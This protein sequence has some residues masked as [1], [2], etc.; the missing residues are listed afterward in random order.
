MAR[1]LLRGPVAAALLDGERI[2]ATSEVFA[3][4]LGLSPRDCQGRRL[5][6]L[7][8]PEG[9][10]LELPSRGDA[11]SYR[12][13]LGGVA[14]RVDLSS[15]AGSRFGIAG[16]A[17]T[18]E[19]S[20][21]A[22]SRA[23]L[24][25]S[26]ELSAA[27]SEEELEGAVARALDLL[28][29]GR[30][31][32]IR[33]LDPAT[34]ALTSMRARGRLA[35]AMRHRLALRRS[36]VEKTGLSERKLLAA[37]AQVV[38]RDEPVFAGC[39]RATAVP[40]AVGGSLH[41]LVNLEYERGAPGTP[42]SDEPLLLQVANQAALAARNLR[43]REELKH[44]KSYLEDL[45]ENAP[46]L[47]AVVNRERELTVFN[48]AL[49]RLTGCPREEALGE[50]FLDLVPDG[51]RTRVDAL[52]EKGLAGRP[53]SGFETRLRL[54]SGGEAR[55]AINTSAVTGASGEVEGVMAIGHDTT[56]LRA[57]QERAEHGQRL[58][59]L[60][61][62]AAGV[63]HE[64]NNPLTAVAAYSENLLGKM[65]A[66]G[67]DPG[68][69]DKLRRIREAAG[70]LQRLSRD[71]MAYARPP[72]EQ[73][74][75]VDLADVI[76]RAATMCEPALKGVGARLE[77]QLE[78]VPVVFGQRDSLVQVFVNLISNAVQAL[79]EG[80][81][82]IRLELAREGNHVAARVRDDGVGMAPDVKKRIFEPFFTT[83]RDGTG[84]G[85]G[86][87]IVQGILARHAGAMSVESAPGLGTTFTVLFPVDL[88]P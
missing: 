64:L 22:Q 76:E 36:S 55:I 12:T 81:G 34:L 44:F 37:G 41:G 31:F 26:R 13:H 85:L 49:V 70:R 3:R 20:D 83:R 38:E 43:T 28:F 74:E 86:L 4:A 24:S 82:A 88:Q 56:L 30:S 50:D 40:L 51:E 77:R 69:L 66:A 65:A 21:T 61:K 19:D 23:L 57:L 9:H 67:G 79:P 84:T 10:E 35:P 7:L 45:I 53:A 42:E 6:D 75:P 16:L 5:A 63:V 87:P 33:L 39:D 8:P 1:A 46:A 52:L 17:L 80:G 71:L 18:L 60:G 2:A 58:V 29:P 27:A 15:P 59:E 48:Q 62:L 73:R 11:V 72:A 47:I 32:S 25:L 14:A 78:P 54:R 68:D